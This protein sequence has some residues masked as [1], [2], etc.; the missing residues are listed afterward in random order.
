MVRRRKKKSFGTKKKG[1]KNIYL[2]GQSHVSGCLVSVGMKSSKNCK[3]SSLE[4][5]NCSSKVLRMYIY[6]LLFFCDVKVN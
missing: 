2:L 1:R 6:I 4:C 5:K 3:S